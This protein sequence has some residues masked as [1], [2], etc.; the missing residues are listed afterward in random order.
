MKKTFY[1]TTILCLFASVQL[2]GQCRVDT[3]LNYDNGGNG[4]ILNLKSRTIYTY[5]S[6][7]NKIV[8]AALSQ[9]YNSASRLWVNSSKVD[10]T[11]NASNQETL[12]IDQSWSTS[13]N[14]WVNASKIERTYSSGNMNQLSSFGWNTTTSVWTNSSQE[15]YTYNGDNSVTET[16]LKF[17]NTGS[18]TFV[19]YQKTT[20][21]YNITTKLNSLTYEEIWNTSTNVWVKKNKTT[22]TQGISFKP[23][24]IRLD[25]WDVASAAYYLENNNYLKYNTDDSLIEEKT[26]AYNP[27]TTLYDTTYK[28]IYTYSL[29]KMDAKEMFKYDVPSNKWV[30]YNAEVYNYASSGFMTS[31]S[32]YLQWDAGL[33][34]FKV[35]GKTVY[36]CTESSTNINT[37]QST[38]S[39]TIYPNPANNGT[40]FIETK[41]ITS[42]SICNSLGKLI[43]NGQLELG[44]NTVSI[45]GL[46]SGIYFISVNNK[47]Q[48]LIIQ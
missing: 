37:T 43:L 34:E 10:Y 38:S 48:K 47:T 8:E 31:K 45:N 27:V 32:R 28:T 40:L 21:N 6:G 14:T 25:V 41:E 36:L 29:N 9:N 17:W 33:K 13:S 24:R 15:S 42:Y 39:F 19:N 11:Y 1:I 5:K 4:V 22:Y 20:F 16:I 26:V 35:E 30:P 2:M 18:N 7:S 23:I 12:K 44:N 3:I 46:A